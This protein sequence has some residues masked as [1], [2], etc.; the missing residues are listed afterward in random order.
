VLNDGLGVDA[1]IVC[2]LG[3]IWLVRYGL[4]ELSGEEG[5][6]VIVWQLRELGCSWCTVP[7]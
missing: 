2:V 4:G 1:G 6:E 7:Y 5:E 3:L